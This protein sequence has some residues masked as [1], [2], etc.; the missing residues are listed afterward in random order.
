[1]ATCS[2]V[3]A[4][5]NTMDRGP[6]WATVHGVTRSQ[7]HWATEHTHMVQHFFF[8]LLAVL[9][10][11]CCTHRLLFFQCEG[12]R[13]RGLSSCG[14]GFSR[15]RVWP[16]YLCH[17]SFVAHGLWNLSSLT[18]DWTCVPAIWRWILNRWTT[19]EI[20]K[21][22]CRCFLISNASKASWWSSCFVSQRHW[23][24]EWHTD[25]KTECMIKFWNILLYTCIVAGLTWAESHFFH[26]GWGCF[27][28]AKIVYLGGKCTRHSLR[29]TT[30]VQQELVFWISWAYMVLD[31]LTVIL[32][33]NTYTKF[34]ILWSG[35]IKHD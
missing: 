1:M 8:L 18:K 32:L 17:T 35:Y 13:A 23:S 9:G 19:K 21:H 7:T 33:L 5:E 24:V 10:L 27:Q 28:P 29:T 14:S 12:C 4:M 26:C 22:F 2:I 3:F 20:P 30:V 34:L 16:L 6:W 15:C 11:R 31:K 25:Y